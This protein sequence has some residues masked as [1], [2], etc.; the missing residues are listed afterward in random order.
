MRATTWRI[1][2]PPRSRAD[3]AELYEP[4]AEEKGLALKVEAPGPI[5]GAR[6]SRAGQ[7]GAGQSGRQRH[8]ICRAGGDRRRR[9]VVTAGKRGRPGIARR[10]PTTGRAFPKPTGRTWS[11][12]SCGWSKA[13]RKPGSGPGA[14]PRGRGGAAAWRGAQTDRQPSRAAGRHCLAARR[15]GTESGMTPKAPAPERR[16]PA[17][18]HHWPVRVTRRAGASRQRPRGA[19]AER[20]HRRRRL[21]ALAPLFAG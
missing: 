17:A 7:P 4:L 16:T 9:I 18:R 2:T 10:S 20:D 1:S 12:V 3:V 14:E 21:S 5:T 13:A 8:Q 6:Q 11:S 19:L 15:A